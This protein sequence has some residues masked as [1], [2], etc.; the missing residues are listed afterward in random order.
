MHSRSPRVYLVLTIR[1]LA[2]R[3]SEVGGWCATASHLVEPGR[4][5]AQ[6]CV[7]ARYF[8]KRTR[9]K[10]IQTAQHGRFI[11]SV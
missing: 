5:A 1:A 11:G 8:L 6:C 2:R 9:A 10:L 3:A 4:G 7:Q